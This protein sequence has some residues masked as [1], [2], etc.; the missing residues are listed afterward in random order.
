MQ[1]NDK[2]LKFTIFMLAFLA[3]VMAFVFIFVIPAVKEFKLKKAEY[4]VQIKEEKKL[5]QKEQELQKEL[6]KL[7]KKYSTALEGFKQDFD[8]KAF[9]EMAKKY[10][11]NVKL[12]PKET[13]KMESGLHIYEF[14]ADFSALTPV[15]FYQFI[16]SLNQMKNIV[17]INF[18]VEL[19]AKNRT[20]ALRFNMSVYR[21]LP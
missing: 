15:K 14:Q 13:H 19:D 20:I 16:D 3:I 17:K 7:K 18:P 6:E 8:E 9:L 10:F 2:T 4:Y 21:L 5:A 12:T 11:Q 1:V